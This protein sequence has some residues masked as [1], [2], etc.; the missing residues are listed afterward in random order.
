MSYYASSVS[1]YFW[2]HA[3]S[4]WAL[5]TIPDP[6]D[7]DPVRYAMFASIV[8]ELVAAFNWRL[9]FGLRR[10]RQN[11]DRSMEN[12]T[13]PYIPEVAPSWTAR[14]PAIQQEWLSDL[15]QDFVLEGTLF[16]DDGR[17]FSRNRE[18]PTRY[19]YTV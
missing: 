14:V 16:L 15:P 9:S 8:E 4:K 10:N 11:V 3:E 6:C 12:P 5:A 19:L 17:L 1:E 7:P 2:R 18:A 13:P